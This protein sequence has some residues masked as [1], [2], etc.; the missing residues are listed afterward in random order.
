MQVESYRTC[1]KTLQ[2]LLIFKNFLY[3]SK[4]YLH[5]A[6]R[7]VG[8]PLNPKSAICGADSP[9]EAP[10][11]GERH[12]PGV[13]KVGSHAAGAREPGQA[14]TG[15]AMSVSVGVLRAPVFVLFSTGGLIADVGASGRLRSVVVDFT[16]Y[17]T[18]CG[19]ARARFR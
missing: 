9:P 8:G 12:D 11:V 3:W 14:L 6:R 17:L 13:L 4:I 7:G 16:F 2:S 18:A 5:H 19:A 1:K 10:W 15:A